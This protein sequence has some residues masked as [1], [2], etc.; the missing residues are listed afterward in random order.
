MNSLNRL[1]RATPA[2]AALFAV[3]AFAACNNGASSLPSITI[4]S[5]SVP[6]V[7]ASL[8]LSGSGLTGCVDPATFAILGQLEA[9]GAD[10]PTLI[11]QNKPALIAGLQA[12]QPPDTATGTWRDQLVGALQ[13][14]DTATATAKVQMLT[15]GE[16]AITSC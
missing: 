7:E 12:F 16:V 8:S 15:S 11:D 10:V 4:P 3:A 14:N 13:S 1:H 6:S 5:F 9:Q 2:I